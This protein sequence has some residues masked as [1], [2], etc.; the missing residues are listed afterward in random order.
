MLIHL[1]QLYSVLISSLP[2]TSCTV[3]RDVEVFLLQ[4]YAQFKNC[5][6]LMTSQ[7]LCV[8]FIKLLAKRIVA[9]KRRNHLFASYAQFS[10]GL[11]Y[12]AGNCK[13][14]RKVDLPWYP[15]VVSKHP[16]PGGPCFHRSPLVRNQLLRRNEHV[17]LKLVSKDF[18]KEVTCY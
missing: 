14:S 16:Y 4:L 17:W 2:C 5:G 7:P 3:Y 15:E 12:V 1:R 9:F 6:N 18:L 8:N 10:G 11:L 13:R